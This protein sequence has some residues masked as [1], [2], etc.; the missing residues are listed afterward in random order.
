MLLK[1]EIYT[2]GRIIYGT[3]RKKEDLKEIM[4]LRKFMEGDENV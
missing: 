1:L 3:R 4:G 2:M